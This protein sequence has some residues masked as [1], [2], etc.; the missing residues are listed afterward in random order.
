[1]LRLPI[2][3][4]ILAFCGIG[5]AAAQHITPQQI[6][7]DCSAGHKI[8]SQLNTLTRARPL[9]FE[10]SGICQED[11]IIRRHDV[12]IKGAAANTRTATIRGSVTVQGSTLVHLKDLTIQ[13]DQGAQYGVTIEAGSSVELVN[14]LV[15]GH[16]RGAV[17]VLRNSVVDTSKSTFSAGNEAEAT[18][19]IAD[20]GTLVM[21]DSAVVANRSE[22]GLGPA[23]GV[24]R[25]ASVRLLANNTIK[26]NG[27]NDDPWTGAAM[28]VLDGSNARIQGTPGN[29]VVGNIVV[30]D[31][32]SADVRDTQITGNLLVQENS[33]FEQRDTSPI[34]G[35]VIVERRGL[36][37]IRTTITGTVNCS[38]QGAVYGT[39]AAKVS[40]IGCSVL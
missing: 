23:I 9:I 3:L 1:M 25:R 35:D 28:V 21:R 30:S 34:R 27:A 33:L 15:K 16:K 38:G 12:V 2:L 22:S 24:Y 10:I 4:C 39:G 29:T 19:T 26:H 37:D 8:Q 6:K 31:Q 36:M 7:L 18:L 17:A 32:S 5:T 13:D 14:I 11:L 40:L 20:G